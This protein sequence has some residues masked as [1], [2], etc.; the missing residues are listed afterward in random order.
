M[1]GLVVRIL[2]EHKKKGNE[3]KE[4]RFLQ[5]AVLMPLAEHIFLV[6]EGIR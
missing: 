4:M 6:C 5:F 3:D 1:H 2:T